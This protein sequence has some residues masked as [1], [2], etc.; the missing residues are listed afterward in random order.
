MA[1]QNLSTLFPDSRWTI[2]STVGNPLTVIYVYNTSVST[3]TNGGR[4]CL[5]TVPAN[6][7]WAKFEVWGGGGGGGGA[8]CCQQQCY[9]GGSG[10]YARRTISVTPGQQ[11]TICAGGSSDCSLTC[12]GSPGF[13][14]YACLTG[15][16]ALC[17]AAG[18]QGVT[19][20][21][22]TNNACNSVS[23]QSGG[24]CGHDLVICG[25]V[26][27]ANATTCGYMSW[28]YGSEPTYL[29]GGIRASIDQCGL[30]TGMGT[31]GCAS[32]P[33]GGGSGAQASGGPCYQGGVGAGGLVVITYK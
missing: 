6:A 11:Y 3:A 4:C 1:S 19:G 28:A 5:F 17:A 27:G 30:G 18:P 16:L 26:S 15:T 29:G 13:P 14:S 8:C 22:Y 23:Y 21:F 24:A 2:P 9:S 20:C 32:F 10:T 31:G 33:G 25:I 7:T 12:L